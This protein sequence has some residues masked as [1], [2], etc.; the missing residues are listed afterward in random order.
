M[1]PPEQVLVLIYDDFRRDNEATVR[2]VLRFLEVDEDA[3][4]EVMEANPTVRV[5][6][7]AHRRAA[8][9]ALT[10]GRRTGRARREGV[11]KALAPR[12]LRR[13]ALAAVRR[14][15]VYGSPPAR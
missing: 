1:F 12:A 2:A 13:K 15:V 11:V 9:L 6:S 3:P 8:A 14:R 10:V 7:H 5:R 4:I